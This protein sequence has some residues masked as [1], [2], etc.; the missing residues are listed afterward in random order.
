MRRYHAL[1]LSLGVEDHDL[2]REAE[3]GV[4]LDLLPRL[5]LLAERDR[6]VDELVSFVDLAHELRERLPGVEIRAHLLRRHHHRAPAE[7]R[8]ARTGRPPAAEL[9]GAVDLRSERLR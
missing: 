8:R 4:R 2:R 3:R 1:E 6:V 5:G 7:E 9:V